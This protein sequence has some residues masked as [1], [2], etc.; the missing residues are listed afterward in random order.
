MKAGKSW[1]SSP[2]AIWKYPDIRSMF[3]KY[4]L[5]SRDSLTSMVKASMVS[6]FVRS[7]L[8]SL[9]PSNSFLFLA[10][11]MIVLPHWI[12]LVRISHLIP[13]L[14]KFFTSF[15]VSQ[16][17]W[18]RMYVILFISFCDK[19][20]RKMSYR[21]NFLKILSFYTFWAKWNLFCHFIRRQTCWTCVHTL[22]KIKFNSAFG[23]IDLFVLLNSWIIFSIFSAQAILYFLKLSYILR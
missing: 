8:D 23:I 12:L 6:L 15:L 21:L 1:L 16:I 17:S 20:G 14:Q 3:E 13:G 4:M 5:P 2:S 19:F 9:Q 11:V 7:D 18:C 10:P 22:L